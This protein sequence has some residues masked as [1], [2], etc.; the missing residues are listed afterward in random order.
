MKSG[1]DE[2]QAETVDSIHVSKFRILISRIM[3]HKDQSSEEDNNLLKEGPFVLIGDV[4]DNSVKLTEGTV[5]TGSFDKVKF[6]VH[7]FSASETGQYADDNV[8][9]PH[10]V[11]QFLDC[12]EQVECTKQSKTD[13]AGQSS[14]PKLHRRRHVEKPVQQLKDTGLHAG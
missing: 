7:R 13:G 14:G 10:P 11:R 2:I 3:M 4:P 5:P 1:K 8:F 12:R 9:G 6:E